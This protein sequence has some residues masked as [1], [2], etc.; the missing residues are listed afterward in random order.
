MC[1]CHRYFRW[2]SSCV[3]I[4]EHSDSVIVL[5]FNPCATEDVDHGAL[6]LVS[7]WRQLLFLAAS[8]AGRLRMARGRLRMAGFPL[9]SST[10]GGE[11]QFLGD[12]P[13]SFLLCSSRHPSWCPLL[14]CEAGSTRPVVVYVTP[15]SAVTHAHTSLVV[16]F[17]PPAPT[18]AYA[19]PVTTRTATPTVFQA[20]THR[21]TARKPV[22]IPQL[23]ILDKVTWHDRCCATTGFMVL[24][25]QKACGDST[26]ADLGHA[27]CCSTTGAWSRPCG[28]PWR[29]H[30]CKS[31]TRLLGMPAVVQRQ[32]S[33]S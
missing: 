17:V 29:F 30:S 7:V 4:R 26:V 11:R 2:W 14:F 28:S 5:S 3:E 20:G 18:V 16:V 15:A 13:V 6:W 1:W 8:V 23:Q 31:W 19:S 21:A 9:K 32:V 27:G 24:T 25:E 10:D 22:E 33:W 12:R